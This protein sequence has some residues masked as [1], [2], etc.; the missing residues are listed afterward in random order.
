LLRTRWRFLLPIATGERHQEDCD[1]R[2]RRDDSY[3]SGRLHARPFGRV[4]QGE[5][6][7]LVPSLLRLEPPRRAP[8][9]RKSP[10]VAAARRG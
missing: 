2:Q 6:S 5:E 3:S 9:R 4:T 10:R 7:D 1:N 8:G